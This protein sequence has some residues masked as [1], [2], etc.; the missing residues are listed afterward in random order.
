MCPRLTNSKKLPVKWTSTRWRQR[1]VVITPEVDGRGL[2]GL[3]R[4]MRLE[5]GPLQAPSLARPRLGP[6]M[7]RKSRPLRLPKLSSSMNPVSLRSGR[8]NAG[9]T[10]IE[11][12]VVISII[13][14][15]ASMA[16][17]VLSRAKVKAQ[18]AKAQMEI[19]DFAGAINQYVSTYSRMPVSK[20][21]RSALEDPDRTPDFT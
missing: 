9:F 10:L 11:L 15:L 12:L 8:F 5:V 2:S 19:N 17:P 21:T 3:Q 6:A 14:V 1:I 20:D 18:V 13:G 4:Q 7:D 16:L